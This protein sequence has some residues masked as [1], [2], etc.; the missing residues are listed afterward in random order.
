VDLVEV[1]QR[2]VTVL[3]TG[4]WQELIVVASSMPRS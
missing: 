2:V 3:V 1:G 4:T